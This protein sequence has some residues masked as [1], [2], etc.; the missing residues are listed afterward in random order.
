MSRAL[1]GYSE[2]PGVRGQDERLLEW[3]GERQRRGEATMFL[4]HVGVAM[5]A[6]YYAPRIS[7]GSL[8]LGAL[9]LDL[10]SSL[11]AV[12]GIIHLSPSF[13]GIG[14]EFFLF[15]R[16]SLVHSLPAAIV[17]TVL[18]ASFVFLF[19]RRLA[20]VLIIGVVVFSHWLLNVI[21][22][23]AFLP[24]AEGLFPGLG[25]RLWPTVSALMIFEAALFFIGICLYCAGTRCS[26][27]SGKMGFLGMLVFL[28]IIQF[29]GFLI[30]LPL[31][32]G[33]ASLTAILITGVVFWGFW[34]ER[35]RNL[36]WLYRPDNRSR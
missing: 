2:R 21:L 26:S 14:R 22:G 8:L 10:L 19:R 5:G 33:T 16:N 28:P 3:E 11:L 20:D 31:G 12:A 36:K 15:A 27:R 30:P 7:L 1:L 17:W 13:P 35:H 24:L 34:M 9:F 32:R 4:G 25:D 18:F 23:R 29:I 6:K